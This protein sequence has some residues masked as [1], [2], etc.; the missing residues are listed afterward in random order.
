MAQMLGSGQLKTQGLLTHT[1]P[2]RQAAA[3]FDLIDRHP[4]QV[5]KV[6]MTF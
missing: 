3:A 5:I 1:F 2:Y 4:E 6:A